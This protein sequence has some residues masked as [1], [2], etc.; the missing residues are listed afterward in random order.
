ME[1]LH[2]FIEMIVICKAM[3]CV[4][5]LSPQ[6]I[7]RS[8][9]DSLNS[10]KAEDTDSR[11]NGHWLYTWIRL[12]I[13]MIWLSAWNSTVNRKF[14]VLQLWSMICFFIS[15]LVLNNLWNKLVVSKVSNSRIFKAFWI[16]LRIGLN[17]YIACYWYQWHHLNM[18]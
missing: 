6:S 1:R 11:Q 13:I 7:G 8:F 18:K 3:C 12:I 14:G 16:L 2:D 4:I 17:G 5:A 10:N 15:L 9:L